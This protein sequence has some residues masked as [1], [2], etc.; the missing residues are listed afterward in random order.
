MSAPEITTKDDTAIPKTIFEALLQ[1]PNLPAPEKPPL[2]FRH[3][4]ITIIG[5]GTITISF[6]LTVILFDLARNPSIATKLR[7]ELNSAPGPLP[8]SLQQLEQLPYLNAVIT[9]ALRLV[10]GE[11]GRIDRIATDH[12]TVYH[13]PDSTSASKIDGKEIQYIIPPGF[14]MSM[15]PFHI[16]RQE[17]LLSKPDEYI[18]ERWSEATDEEKRKMERYLVSFVRGSRMCLGVK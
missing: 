2:H 15:T 17:K 14:E 6:T 3:K 12:A 5:A 13:E 16:S 1:D 9:E 10:P 4:A 8:L 18:P 11:P 7:E